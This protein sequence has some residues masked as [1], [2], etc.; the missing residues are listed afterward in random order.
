VR[1]SLTRL[2]VEGRR[3]MQQEEII[4]YETRSDEWIRKLVRLFISRFR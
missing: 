2:E 3:I 4:G 1:V